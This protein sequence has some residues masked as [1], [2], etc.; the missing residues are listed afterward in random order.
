M[1]CIGDHAPIRGMA[2]SRAVTDKGPRPPVERAKV[3][4]GLEQGHP[5]RPVPQRCPKHRSAAVIHGQPR[6]VPMPAGL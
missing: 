6:S 2:T 5:R 3:A 4:T 1:A